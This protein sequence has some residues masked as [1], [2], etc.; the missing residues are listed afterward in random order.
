MSNKSSSSPTWFKTI[1]KWLALMVFPSLATIL[2]TIPP[3][4]HDHILLTV[5]VIVIYECMLFVV[6]LLTKIWQQ[7]EEQWIKQLAD[8]LDQHVHTVLSRYHHHYCRNFH[9]AHQDLDVKGMS[10]QGT[11]TLE[12]EHIFVDLRLDSKPSH[13]ASANLVPLPMELQTESHSI[14]EFLQASALHPHHLVLLGAPGSG[15]TTLVKHLGLLLVQRKRPRYLKRF[16]HLIPLL[17][18]LREHSTAIA[19][20]QEYSLVDAVHAQVSSWNCSMPSDWIEQRLTREHCLVLLDGLDEVADPTH[21]QQVVQW[22]EKQMVIYAGNRFVITSRPYGYRSNPLSGVTTLEV[23]PFCI[24]QITKFV[25]NW[26]LANEI[27]SAMRDD[28]GVRMRAK[29]EAQDLLRR[30]REKEVLIELAVNPLY[31]R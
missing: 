13:Q 31:S 29:T 10:T 6:Y 8:I 3:F 30:L 14:W 22:V 24:E 7:K 11:F 2:P 23:Q 1:L 18:F 28:P 12:L 19:E 9:Y 17:L 20:K 21:R 27:K 15:K 5:I 16:P 26:Y 25:N 4:V